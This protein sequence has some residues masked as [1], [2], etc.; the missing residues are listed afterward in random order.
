VRFHEGPLQ[1]TIVVGLPGTQATYNPS[2]QFER[3]LGSER[4]TGIQTISALILDSD[5]EHRR[6]ISLMVQGTRS[7]ASAVNAS[8]VGTDRVWT[9]G[10]L[11]AL[12]DVL[13][14]AKTRNPFGPRLRVVQPDDT[15]GPS[16]RV[17]AIGRDIVLLAVGAIL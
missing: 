4:A 12:R 11:A 8:V 1:T 2:G 15:A 16:A 9:D 13:S 7:S 17:S 6:Q 14:R 5:G 3:E 10:A